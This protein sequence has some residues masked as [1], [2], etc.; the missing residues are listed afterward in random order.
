MNRSNKS[1][2]LDG[3]ESIYPDEWIKFEYVQNIVE[4]TIKK[5]G[6]KKISAPSVERRSL[7]AVKPPWSEGLINQTFSFFD[8]Q[9]NHLTLIPEQTPTRARM[10]Q[11]LN[12]IEIPIRWYDTSKRWRQE[13]NIKNDRAKEFWQ[14]DVDIIGSETVESDAEVIA[15]VSKIYKN[16][17]LDKEVEISISDRKLL[18]S[19]LFFAG[20]KSNDYYTAVKIVD[21]KEKISSKEFYDRFRFMGL[22][23]KQIDFISKMISL[24]GPILKCIKEIKQGSKELAKESTQIIERIICLSK[25]LKW[26]GVY[27]MCILD[28]SIARGSFY[29]GMIFEV[30]DKNKKL[31]ALSGGGR[32]DWLIKMYGKRDLPAIGFGFG[33][34]GTLEKLKQCK[35][36]S[37]AHK[38]SSVYVSCENLEND[39]KMAIKIANSLREMGHI[40]EMDIEKKSNDIKKSEVYILLKNNFCKNFMAEISMRGKTNII[41]IENFYSFSRKFKV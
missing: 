32:Y 36:L 22:A 19:I 25:I 35:L 3:F 16:L 38:E 18:E 6:F 31:G 23:K 2:S 1:K 28:L 29:T 33:Y 40:V 34:L 37:L 17:G 12:E 4:K 39:Y 26:Y 8:N 7:Y 5:F 21:D 15:C 10:V 11:E 24:K 20:I 27:D 30:S 14:T 41:R 13:D 9:K